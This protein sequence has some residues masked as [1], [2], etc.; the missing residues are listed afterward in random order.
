MTSYMF[1]YR[2]DH[3]MTTRP[4]VV[5]VEKTI[6]T[7]LQ[8]LVVALL[9]SSFFDQVDLSVARA[10]AIA[11]IPAALTVLV[12][13]TSA[14]TIPTSLPPLVQ[15]VLRI[16]R[17]AGV[18]FLGYLIAIPTFGLERS[19]LHAALAAA[20]VALLAAV[21]AEL[22]QFIGNPQTVAWLP[23]HLDPALPPLHT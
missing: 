12:N 21:K 2:K 6:A 1:P 17:T 13:A 22:G 5:L 7:Y 19:I 18:A 8:A 10:L 23:E 9:G 20:G 4:L 14:A 15:A 16:L 11:A 3:P